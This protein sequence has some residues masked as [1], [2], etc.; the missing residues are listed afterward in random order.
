MKTREVV[1]WGK[2]VIEGCKCLTSMFLF[3]SETNEKITKTKNMKGAKRE[4]VFK[5][6]KVDKEQEVGK[7]K[8]VL[9][10]GY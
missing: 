7:G 5:C 10:V 6:M 8:V 2:G 4:R 1:G 9:L 3:T